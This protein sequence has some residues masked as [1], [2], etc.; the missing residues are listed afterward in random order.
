MDSTSLRCSAV[1]FV[2]G[3]P[4]TLRPKAVPFYRREKL[5][6]DPK[7]LQEVFL[8]IVLAAAR[9]QECCVVVR[10]GNAPPPPASAPICHRQYAILGLL[11]R[12]MNIE[13]CYE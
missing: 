10:R 1:T 2:V 3:L 6:P 13:P 12:V 7:N 4:I 9:L 11:N 5:R 8:L